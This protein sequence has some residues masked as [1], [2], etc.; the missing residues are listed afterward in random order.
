MELSHRLEQWKQDSANY[1]W[2]NR[3]DILHLIQASA[4]AARQLLKQPQ[5]IL[6]II[7]QKPHWEIFDFQAAVQSILESENE[8]QLMQEL[9]LAKHR[10]QTALIHA[11]VT[12]SLDEPSFLTAISQL[13]AALLEIAHQWHY[14]KL[15]ERY[16]TPL[17]EQHNPLTLTILGMGKFGGGELNFSSDIDLI[18]AYRNN[19]DT[20][21]SGKQKSQD[22]EV[23]F[24]KLAQKI[25]NTV[26][27]VTEDGFLYR[28]DMRLRPF[29]QTGPLAL[30]YSALETYYQVHGRDWERY[31]MMKA[32]PIAGD[33]IGGQQ[34]LSDLRPFMYRRYLDYPALSSIAE[35]KQSIN[36]Q[37]RENG[38]ET[39]IKLGRGGIREAE[40]SVQ[41]MQLVYGGQYPKLQN[42]NFLSILND[43]STL[44]FWDANETEKLRN[45][46][47]LL[48]KVENALQFDREQQTH[49]LPDTDADWQ[50]LT[51][52]VNYPNIERL[53]TDLNAAREIIHRR[54]RSIFANLNDANPEQNDSALTH[55][56]WQQ[57]DID[58]TTQILETLG[59]SPEE[60]HTIATSLYQFSQTLSWQRLPAKTIERLERL[61]PTLFDIAARDHFPPFAIEGL[62]HLIREVSGRSVYINMMT[63]E[64]KLIRHLLAIA[65]DSRWLMQ[66]IQAHPLVLDD[67]LSERERITDSE[68]L[69]T[70]LSARLKDLEDEDWLNALRD[71]KH[72]Q[73]FKIA[74]AEVHGNLPLM[75]V[76]DNLTHIAEL[77]LEK[78]YQHAW[79]H[80]MKRHGQPRC[81]NGNIATF[82]I[83]GY[84]KLG[85]LEMG[86]SS[87]LD[88]V[89]LYDDE[90]SQGQTDG[91]KPIANQLFFARLV[92][93]ISSILSI[94]STSGVLYELDT[95]LRPGG[96]SGLPAASIEAFADYQYQQAWIW[97]HQALTRARA[98]CG[99]K[100][101]CEQFKHLRQQILSQA[102]KSDL[103]EAVLNMRQKMLDN[104]PAL[105]SNQFHLKKSRG[106]LI[107]IEFIVQYLL[108]ANAHEE[109]ILLRMSDNIRQLAALEATGILSSGEA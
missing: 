30:S 73:V 104:E 76:S 82:A 41:A 9:R 50:R 45:A 77:I 43:L 83:I 108:L 64:P 39:H 80:L 49:R 8:A 42:P 14:Q 106:G 24:R 27:Q 92:Q 101:L 37:I 31:A 69:A 7:A 59:Y 22:H 15:T 3:E 84:G 81:A 2:A 89:F 86:Y 71:F 75:Q 46:Y 16:G 33:I 74:W 23:F 58:D 79:N 90:R 94:S 54:F 93:R 51:L 109:P 68:Q 102:P 97:E 87:D 19:G 60:S 12:Q 78:A 55:L 25:I 6:E 38:M 98:I 63:D 67:I 1:P 95:R 13:A 70:D 47:L 26:D 36:R 88:L 65:R 21:V 62:L 105:A 91:D 52:A 53:Q 103:R 17:D 99:D 28:V 32:R 56:N 100:K 40:F 35:M 20:H 72:A 5:A 85:G 34:L 29:G 66:F 44:D 10:Y 57:P 96:K 11:V 107:D 18:F 61:L 4:Y 48:R